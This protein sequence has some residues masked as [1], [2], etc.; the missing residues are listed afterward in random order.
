MSH[1]SRTVLWRYESLKGDFKAEL[2]VD[3]WGIVM[4]YGQYWEAVAVDENAY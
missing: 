1:W 4:K 3:E 2:T